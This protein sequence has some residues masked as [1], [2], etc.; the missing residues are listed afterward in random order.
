M[1]DGESA[2]RG[3]L[4]DNDVLSTHWKLYHERMPISLLDSG[5]VLYYLQSCAGVMGVEWAA[6]L[7]DWGFQIFSVQIEY[8]FK[9]TESNIIDVG[10]PNET[11][12]WDVTMDLCR[13][14]K[15]FM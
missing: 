2:W 6:L 14:M 7:E 8:P 12:A 3:T 9:R 5:S 10:E 13:S 4:S 15:V 11:Y 1:L